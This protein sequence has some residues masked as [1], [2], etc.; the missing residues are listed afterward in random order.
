MRN[1]SYKGKMEDAVQV[2]GRNLPI[3][4]KIARE[5]AVF[6]KGKTVARAIRDLNQVAAG[7]LA[8]PYVRFN[9]DTPH[10]P[11]HIMSGRF[12]VKASLEIVKLLESLKANAENKALDGDAIKIVHASCQHG[13]RAW[14]YGRR[15]RRRRKLAH[16]ELVG[17]EAEEKEKKY[18]KETPKKPEVKPKKET[19]KKTVAKP[20]VEKK[21]TP[22]EAVTPVIKTAPA[23]AEKKSDKKEKTKK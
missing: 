13:T 7:K 8:V 15:R 21:A 22:K 14:H 4:R 10:R 11:G 16:F 1:I 2:A 20:K 12:P 23:P 19:P 18:K 6:I 9:R 17:V 3:S 5:I